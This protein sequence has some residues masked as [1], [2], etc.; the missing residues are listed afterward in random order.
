MCIRDRGTDTADNITDG[1]TKV[2]M[3]AVERKKLGGIEEGA[4]V[5]DAENCLLYTS[6]LSLTYN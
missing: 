5:T 6:T 3:T 2:I 4:D 1:T